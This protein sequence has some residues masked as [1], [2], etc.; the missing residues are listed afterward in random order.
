MRRISTL[1]LATLLLLCAAR[2]APAEMDLDAPLSY[3]PEDPFAWAT[4]LYE[5]EA[6]LDDEIPATDAKVSMQEL[7]LY[8]S[9]PLIW[10][11]PV[12][13]LGGANLRWNRF[14]FKDAGIDDLD[15]Y[16]LGVPFDILYEGFPS[17]EILAGFQPGLYS[18]LEE[19]DGDDF[20]I[21]GYGL[22]IWECIPE[23]SLA[24]GVAYDQ[25]FGADRFYP[26]GGL[27]WNPVRQLEVSLVYPMPKI[28]FAPTTTLVT[29]LFAEPAGDNWSV[30]IENQE[31]NFKLESLRMG[32]GVEY[33]LTTSMWL[34]FSVGVDSDRNYEIREGDDRVID[35]D[36]EDAFYARIGLLMR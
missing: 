9:V 3:V 18:D 5:A 29:Y 24:A 30:Y 20:R 16:T 11:D 19:I 7:G 33:A 2:I 23:L 1:T 21:Y 26:M 14:G 10:D 34:Q 25:V 28:S 32:G 31:Y 17:W 27:I 15:V 13:L 8:G 6:D 22:G 12:M 35:S 36:V 4:F